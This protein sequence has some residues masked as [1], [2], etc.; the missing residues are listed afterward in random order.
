M[1]L[2]PVRMFLRHIC[3]LYVCTYRSQTRVLDTMELKLQVVGSHHL[4]AR[5]WTWVLCKKNELWVMS[6]LPLDF[7][8]TTLF[9]KH[10]FFILNVT[11]LVFLDKYWRFLDPSTL[12]VAL[13]MI[14]LTKISSKSIPKS[15]WKNGLKFC[16]HD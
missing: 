6:S 8:L 2:L 12:F 5:N 4:A 14:D 16:L 9:R 10:G 13:F 7:L 3:A 11:S 15:K 1:I